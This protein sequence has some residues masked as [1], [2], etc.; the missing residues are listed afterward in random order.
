MWSKNL[1]PANRPSQTPR[2]FDLNPPTLRWGRATSKLPRLEA[3]RLHCQPHA[4]TAAPGLGRTQASGEARGQAAQQRQ[5]APARPA[6]QSLASGAPNPVQQRGSEDPRAASIRAQWSPASLPRARVTHLNRGA[7]RRGLCSGALATGRTDGHGRGSGWAGAGPFAD[8]RGRLSA[9]QPRSPGPGH[10]GAHASG[11][12][13]LPAAGCGR[14]RRVP[15]WAPGAQQCSRG[16]AQRQ[17]RR[18]QSQPPRGA[19]SRG[20]GR[21]APQN[22]D[23]SDGAGRRQGGRGK[24]G[25]PSSPAP[26][27]G[28]LPSSGDPS[29]R[30]PR[31]PRE[32]L[33]WW[34]RPPTSLRDLQGPAKV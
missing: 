26:R 32:R 30:C 21:R 16:G 12:R 6:S 17:P 29:R 10:P 22:P 27:G 19:R 23:W 20:A 24:E 31:L 8:R 7:R 15:P 5:A 18:A 14:T 25:G 11:L 33:G 1:S 2:G 9:P 4:L 13:C 34:V 28:P 3:G